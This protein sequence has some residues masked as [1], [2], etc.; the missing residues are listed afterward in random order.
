M[1]D[2]GILMIQNLLEDVDNKVF[3]DKSVTYYSLSDVYGPLRLSDEDLDYEKVT[4][5]LTFY[6]LM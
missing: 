1:T 5:C 2:N 6:E 3:N 4:N